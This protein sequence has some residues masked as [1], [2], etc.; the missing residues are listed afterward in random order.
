MAVNSRRKGKA[1]ELEIVS[2]LKEYGYK[3]ARGQQHIGSAKGGIAGSDDVI[4]LPDIHIEVKRVQQLNIESAM[5]QSR[6]DAHA[7]GSGKI[8]VVFHRRNNER[9]KVTM[10]FDDWMWIYQGRHIEERK[11]K[12]RAGR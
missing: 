10:D 2:M 11:K 12:K 1:G 6:E 9:W 4:G 3:V 8:P 5:K 7:S